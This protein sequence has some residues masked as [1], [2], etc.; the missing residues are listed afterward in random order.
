MNWNSKSNKKHE[1]HAQY[2]CEKSVSTV[3]W[4]NKPRFNSNNVEDEKGHSLNSQI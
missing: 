4:E 3:S 1:N 2:I